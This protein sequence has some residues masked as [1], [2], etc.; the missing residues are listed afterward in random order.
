MVLRIVAG[1][2]PTDPAQIKLYAGKKPVEGYRVLQ[3]T[4]QGQKRTLTVEF[5]Y[6]E[7][8]P[9]EATDQAVQI[10]D[11]AASAEEPQG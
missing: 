6:D 4:H 3:A 2:D 1:V 10:A 8:E 11:E 9:S 7:A 5:E